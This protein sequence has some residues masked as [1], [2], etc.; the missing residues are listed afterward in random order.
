MFSGLSLSPPGTQD[1]LHR[2]RYD[3]QQSLRL[4]VRFPRERPQVLRYQD[5]EGGGAGGGG[6]E[7]FVPSCLRDEEERN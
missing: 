6:H 7:G 3:G 4:R 1:Q 5:G 2:P